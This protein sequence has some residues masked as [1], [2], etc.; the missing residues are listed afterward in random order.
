MSAPSFFRPAGRSVWRRHFGMLGLTLGLVAA[1]PALTEAVQAPAL[2][3]AKNFDRNASAIDVA[4]YWVSEKLDGVRAYWDGEHLVTRG[5]QPIYAPQW[6]VAGLPKQVLD[7]EL[8]MGRGHFERLSATVR[9]LQPDDAAWRAVRFMV[10]EAP[11]VAGTFSERISVLRERVEQAH[12]PWLEAV[13]Q[14][15]VGDAPALQ[16]HLQRITRAGGEGLMLHRADA[17]Y[18]TGRSDALLKLKLW[19]DAEAIVI[20]HLPGRGKHQGRLGALRVRTADGREFSLGTGF[21]DAQRQHPPAVGSAITYRY[22]D[23]TAK[24]LPRFARFWRIS[25]QNLA[26][27]A[28][29]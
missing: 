26:K 20:A 7:G 29:Q 28:E 5:G 11:G 10:Y 21:S 17:F 19:Q 1:F 18:V 2:L 12:C 27:A 9:H 15:R 16:A 13:E 22:N 8:W 25:E 6:F 14:F 3:L 4:R 23:L 24:G